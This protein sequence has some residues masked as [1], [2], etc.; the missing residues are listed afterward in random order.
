VPHVLYHW[1]AIVGSTALAPD[2]KPYT[3]SASQRSLREHLARIGI[4]AEVMSAPEI[5]NMNRV[6]PQLPG[7]LPLVSI[8]ISTRDRVDLLQSCVK[9]IEHKSTYPLLEIVIVDNGSADPECLQ[10]LD[11]LVRKGIQVIRDSSPFNFSALHNLA[12][13]QA[14]GEFVCLMNSNVEILSP[15]WLEEMLSFAALPDIGAVGAKLWYPNA[16]DGLQHGGVVIGLGGIAGHAHVGLLKG[17]VGY[18]GR[19]ALHHRLI[20]VSAACLLIRKSSYLHVGGLDESI[21]VNLNH[22]DFCLRLHQAGL[23]CVLTP[24]AEMIHHESASR[25]DDLSDAQRERFMNEV[26]FMHQRW[27]DRLSDDPFFSPNLSLQHSDFRPAEKSR[28]K[29]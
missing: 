8:L 16:Q 26:Q 20:A 29:N 9:S 17:Q 23:A 13:Q 27:G 10:Y 19:A 2:Q 11:S 22:V 6:K 3:V 25:G 12:A 4:S 18:F 15:N 14:N 21:G 24:Y 5:P 7:K 1:R 28:T